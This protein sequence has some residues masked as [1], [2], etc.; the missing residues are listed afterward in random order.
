MP[1]RIPGQKVCYSTPVQIRDSQG[2][3]VDTM[4]PS[5]IV[6]ENNKHVI[7]SIPTSNTPHCK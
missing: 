3:V 4:N 7:T 2:N 5:V 1:Q 6:S